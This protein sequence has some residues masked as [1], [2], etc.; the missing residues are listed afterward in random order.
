M[1]DVNCHTK[2]WL[3]TMSH[4]NNN[5][6]TYTYKM[7]GLNDVSTININVSY[8]VPLGFKKSRASHNLVFKKIDK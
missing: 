3:Q 2:I 5:L 6:M 8:F 4:N 7:L 1:L